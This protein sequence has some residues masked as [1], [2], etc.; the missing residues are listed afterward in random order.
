M[1]PRFEVG[2]VVQDRQDGTIGKV[3]YLYKEPEIRN[4][5]IAVWFRDDA[6]PL[7]VPIDSIKL[8]RTA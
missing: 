5:I 8:V 6:A 2:D 1:K 7:A 4:E 3:V